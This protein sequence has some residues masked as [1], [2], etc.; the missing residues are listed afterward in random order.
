MYPVLPA[1]PLCLSVCLCPPATSP[2]HS[3]WIPGWAVLSHISALVPFSE[4]PVIFPAQ[5]TPAYPSAPGSGVT[6]SVK[7]PLDPCLSVLCIN[8]HFLLLTS[9]LRPPPV[10]G[11]TE[12]CSSS[13]VPC[14][15]PSQKLA[16]SNTDLFLM[17]LRAEWIFC[18]AGCGLGPHMQATLKWELCPGGCSSSLRGLS[19]SG[20]AEHPSSVGC[21]FPR[22]QTPRGQAP[23]TN[24]FQASL[25][26]MLAHVPLARAS[27]V[28]NPKVN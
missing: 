8:D 18:S 28:S 16:A 24:G 4:P 14:N 2:R 15:K 3:L 12:L 26:I 21:W 11:L 5:Q 9:E 20:V 17:S 1:P 7:C 23:C 6:R 27:D 22:E 13:L 10:T 25:R 19:P